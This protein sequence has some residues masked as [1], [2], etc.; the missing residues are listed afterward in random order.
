MS[1]PLAKAVLLVDGYNIIGIW[2]HLQQ[3]RDRQGMEEARRHLVEALVNYSAFEG[4]DTRIIF[5]AH[6][7]DTPASSE[8]VSRNLSIYYTD[9]GQT[10]DTY[11]EKLCASLGRQLRLA[12][13]RLLVATSDRAQQL[14][15]IGYGAEWMSALQLADAVEATNCT[16]RRRHKPQKRSAGRFLASSLDAESQRRL[17]ML[18]MGLK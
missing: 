8:T 14:T 5:D 15:V 3:Q 11:I 18:R 17:A 10:A 2:P 4:L 16:R 7:N 6:Y 12:R 9:Y 13:R 1:R